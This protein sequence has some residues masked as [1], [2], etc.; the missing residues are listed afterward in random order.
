M[1][2]SDFYNL[3]ILS[4]LGLNRTDLLLVHTPLCTQEVL[5][6][7]D[8]NLQ[9]VIEC[10]I[11]H[12]VASDLIQVPQRVLTIQMGRRCQQNRGRIINIDRI[13]EGMV[14]QQIGWITLN[15]GIASRHRLYFGLKK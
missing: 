3:L 4:G 13:Q 1:F 14:P 11:N 8:I 10:L 7:V 6:K 5:H 2:R 15:L 12:L 9:D